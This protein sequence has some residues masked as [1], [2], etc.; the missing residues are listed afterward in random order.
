MEAVA[1]LRT[2]VSFISTSAASRLR[3]LRVS[4]EQHTRRL[5]LPKTAM[6]TSSL[7]RVE[8]KRSGVNLKKASLLPVF[9]GDEEFPVKDPARSWQPPVS[10]ATDGAP[11]A[12]S[13]LDRGR[14][15][16]NKRTP[17]PGRDLR[18]DSRREEPRGQLQEDTH[19]SSRR[20]KDEPIPKKKPRLRLAGESGEGASRSGSSAGG[21]PASFSEDERTEGYYL[22]GLF[23]RV[24]SQ[25][26]SYINMGAWIDQ[27]FGSSAIAYSGARLTQQ[28]VSRYLMK[29]DDLRLCRY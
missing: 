24:A 3:T 5:Y 27:Y 25:C 2:S 18:A 8:F 14:D 12:S 9:S 22:I 7:N 29:G 19:R 6:R 11:V 17:S 15:D 20:Q 23:H 28:I 10:K 13:Q 26:L 1:Q 16:R 21:S 4:D